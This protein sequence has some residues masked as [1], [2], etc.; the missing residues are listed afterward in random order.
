MVPYSQREKQTKQFQLIS[1]KLM[2]WFK[3]NQFHESKCQQTYFYI[4]YLGTFFSVF[5]YF[6]DRLQFCKNEND[7]IFCLI[8]LHTYYQIIE[9][10]KKTHSVKYFETVIKAIKQNYF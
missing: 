5:F 4:K 3:I 9:L 10:T 7:K 8:F 6:L 2:V 1:F